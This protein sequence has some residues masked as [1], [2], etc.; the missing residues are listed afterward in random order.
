MCIRDRV[1]YAKQHIIEQGN[2]RR[3]KFNRT[4][5]LQRFDVGEQILLKANP[6]GK[7]NDNTAKKF[8]RLY[9]GPYTLKQHVGRHTFIVYDK[10]NEKD[11]GKYLSLI[12]I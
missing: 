1:E 10:R 2:K 4:Q 6:V 3:E 11:I 8:F 9:N 5:K 7:R 12:H